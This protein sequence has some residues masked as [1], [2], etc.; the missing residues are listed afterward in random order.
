MHIVESHWRFFSH[1]LRRYIDIPANKAM[2]AY[3][4]QMACRYRGRP[5]T[6]L[7]VIINKELSQAYTDM[8]LTTSNDLQTMRQIDSTSTRPEQVENVYTEDRGVC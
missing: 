2:Q 7:P 6:T 3:F 8:K 4:E 5:T 1:I